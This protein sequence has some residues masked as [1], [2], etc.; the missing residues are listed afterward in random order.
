MTQRAFLG[1]G[2]VRSVMSA[3][4]TPLPPTLRFDQLAMGMGLMCQHGKSTDL[5]TGFGRRGGMLP[6]RCHPVNE[7]Q[8]FF[9]DLLHG[10]QAFGILPCLCFMECGGKGVIRR[11][12][13]SRCKDF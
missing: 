6:L 10:K 4:E 9:R 3:R 8:L 13:V 5:P 1:V 11:V 2:G 12:V 7:G